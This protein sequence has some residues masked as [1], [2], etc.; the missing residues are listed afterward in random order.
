[1]L[2]KEYILDRFQEEAIKSIE[3][4]HS[5]IV[6]APTGAGK[7]LIAEYA[8]EKHIQAEEQIIYTAPIKALSNQKYRDFSR[9]YGDRIGIVTGDV[10]INPEAPILLMTTE[11]FRNTIFDDINRLRNV[12][13]VIFDEIHFIDDIERGT[14]W[15]ES[16]IFA[17]QH[18]NFI[19]LSATIPNLR[20]FAAWMRSV[21]QNRIDVVLETERPVPLEHTLYIKGYG[22]GWIEQLRDIKDSG[23]D[24]EKFTTFKTNRRN[25]KRNFTGTQVM[26]S[27]I[28]GIQTLLGGDLIE[29]IHLSDQLPCLYF[30]LSRKSCEEKALM[31]I[32]RDFLKPNEK[33]LILSEYDD[34][35]QRYDVVND[36]SAQTL[37]EMI[38]H[39][40]AYHH[41]GMLPTLKE[42]VERLFTSGLIRLLFTTET[43][44]LGIN[45]PACSVV[46]DSI[47]K[48]DG[49]QF[50]YLKSREYHQMAGRAGRRGIDDKGFVYACVNPEY[51]DYEDVKGV[52]E[53]DIEKIE[54]QF[55]L[56]Y[57]SVLNLYDKHRDNIYEVCKSSLNNYQNIKT[58]KNLERSMERL[59]KKRKELDELNC[60]HS[61]SAEKI[62]EY[63]RLEEALKAEQS[64]SS[65]SKKSRKKRKKRRR[66]SRKIS[67]KEIGINRALKALKC[68]KCQNFKSCIKTA[69]RIMDYQQRKLGISR[70]IDVMKNYQEQQIKRRLELLQEIGYIDNKGL[71]PR[72][73]VASQ[74]YG[75]EL[76][77]TELLFDGYFH[78]LDPDLMNV[79]IMAIVFE[80]KRDVWYSKMPKK[81]IKPLLSGPDRKISSIRKREG[82]LGIDTPIKE[83]DGKLSSPLYE[84]S[85]GCDFE[86]L[87]DYTDAPPGDLVRYFRLASD[88]LR[89]MRRVVERGD[90]LF[91]KIDIC[92][93]KINRDV[94]DA[95]RQLRVG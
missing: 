94:V 37:R 38:E 59:E 25:N 62:W 47:T 51:D 50:R 92:I 57:S 49:F 16:I 77:V 44:A 7:T 21:R 5:V 34:L 31:N 8:I 54:S 32:D 56:S 79:L 70:Q 28:S 48:Y 17:P 46:F 2:Y 85:R 82:T 89:Q 67:K 43:F 13:Y 12:R 66:K 53:G 55:N 60:I 1:M 14:V 41:A 26:E 35:C 88:L 29:H 61:D 6:A 63:K 65:K 20:E 76:Q 95:E 23:I 86:E 39:G 69:N 45:M 87:V 83:L 52:V 40:V 42:V 73:E 33:K 15:E 30:S 19:C 18:I 90:P 91:S 71:L 4:N 75:Y 24:P 9:D 74:I 84:W 78:R 27:V 58:L 93:S 64:K 80:S 68:S 22:L 36:L 81:I 10:V 11:I 3:N 72:G